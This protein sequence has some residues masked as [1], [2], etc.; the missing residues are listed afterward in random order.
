MPW[1]EIM[2]F[3]ITG[4]WEYSTGCNLKN[5]QILTDDPFSEKAIPVTLVDQTRFHPMAIPAGGER[6]K[7]SMQVLHEA[8]TCR[9]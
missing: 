2:I 9:V 1:K 8:A 3:F 4:E 6:S 7:V 5:R